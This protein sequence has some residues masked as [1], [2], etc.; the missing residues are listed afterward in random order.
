MWIPKFSYP[1][2][3]VPQR[4]NSVGE[5]DSFLTVAANAVEQVQDPV[6]F[7]NSVDS[8]ALGHIG[9]GVGSTARVHP[10]VLPH[11]NA[12][13]LLGCTPPAAAP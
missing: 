8:P 9:L 3:N 13:R 10:R 12:G 7:E 2:M 4:V 5:D 1:S 11:G 6:D